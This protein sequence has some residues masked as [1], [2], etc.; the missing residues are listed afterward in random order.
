MQAGEG[1]LG[2]LTRDTLLYTESVQAVTSLRTMLQDMQRNPHQF[3]SQTNTWKAVLVEARRILD[4]LSVKGIAK[5]R[6]N[7]KTE[8][9]WDANYLFYTVREP[10]PTKTTGTPR[11]IR[12]HRRETG[13][14]EKRLVRS[15][16]K[17]RLPWRRRDKSEVVGT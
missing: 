14:R 2:R 11:C 7:V 13:K 10:F 6:M 4:E 16:V 3:W 5:V 12:S 17:F 15:L 1:T 9:A 8:F